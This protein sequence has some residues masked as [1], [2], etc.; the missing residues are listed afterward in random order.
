MGN[1]F[2]SEVDPQIPSGIRF[3]PLRLEESPEAKVVSDT[4]ATPM[5]NQAAA[6][7]KFERLTNKKR[8]SSP[9]K[10]DGQFWNKKKPE[11]A[12]TVGDLVGHVMKNDKR[13]KDPTPITRRHQHLDTNIKMGMHQDS[14]GEERETVCFDASECDLVEAFQNIDRD[15]DGKITILDM[16]RELKRANP[17]STKSE[18]DSYEEFLELIMPEYSKSTEKIWGFSEFQQFMHDSSKLEK[19]RQ[20]PTIL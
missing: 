9:A 17:F 19:T 1:C 8:K 3:A 12:V 10:V 20:S 18:I 2:N 5:A 14:T 11:L 16:V 6:K 15:R 4:D 7:G 13:S